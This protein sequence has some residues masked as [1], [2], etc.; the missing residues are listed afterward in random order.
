MKASLF[1]SALL[2]LPFSS[3]AEHGDQTLQYFMSNCTVVVSATI[4]SQPERKTDE[5][6]LVRYAFDVEI[7][8]VL[9]AR[10]GSW[11]EK[12]DRIRVGMT[13]Y[14]MNEQDALPFLKKDARCILFLSVWAE[15]GVADPWFGVQ[16][17]NIHMA[18]RLKELSKQNKK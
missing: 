4:A 1:L 9:H 16:P 10:G 5:A 17:Y 14:E 18:N 2:A 8:E 15:T 7:A 12:Q 13:R 3:L 11:F 6:G